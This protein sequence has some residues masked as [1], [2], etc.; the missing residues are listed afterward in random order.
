MFIGTPHRGSDKA[1]YAHVLTDIATSV[2]NK[3]PSRLVNALKENSDQ[4]LQLTADFKHQ[5][6]MYQVLSVYELKPTKPLATLVSTS[7]LMI[8]ALK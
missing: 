2:L 7:I 6:P 8:I 1:N 4:L 5:L 3:P